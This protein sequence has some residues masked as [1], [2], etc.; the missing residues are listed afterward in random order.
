MK[1]YALWD[2]NR[3]RFLMGPVYDSEQEAEIVLDQYKKL[4]PNRKLYVVGWEIQDD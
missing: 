1:K 3:Q 2:H 4:Q